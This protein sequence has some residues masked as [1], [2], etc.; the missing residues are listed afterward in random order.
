MILRDGWGLIGN[1]LVCVNN[2][3]LIRTVFSK[4]LRPSGRMRKD[5]SGLDFFYLG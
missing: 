1:F 4:Q 3:I 2:G 5:S